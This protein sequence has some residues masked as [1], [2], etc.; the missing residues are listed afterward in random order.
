MTGV[1]LVG[2]QSQNEGRVEILGER[3]GRP[4]RGTICDD[5]WDNNDANVVC[6][7]L[8]FRYTYL[9]SGT[10]SLVLTCELCLYRLILF[11]CTLISGFLSYL[12]FTRKLHA[13]EIFM[14][15]RNLYCSKIGSLK[16]AEYILFLV[17]EF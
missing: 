17:C 1:V 12:R 8:G 6:R 9:I 4:V 7:M 15:Y 14:F 16:K 5:N 2:G 11:W 3:G 10:Y 13:C